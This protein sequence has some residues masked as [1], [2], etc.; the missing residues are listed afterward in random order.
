MN[1]FGAGIL[2][3]WIAL[4]L[5]PGLDRFCRYLAQVMS[6][7]KSSITFVGVLLEK[8]HMQNQV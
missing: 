1:C 4:L 7:A 2:L 6:Y 3:G 8:N 5:G